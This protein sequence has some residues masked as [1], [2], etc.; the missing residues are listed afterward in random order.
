MT[1]VK[2]MPYTIY[3]ENTPNPASM[4]FVANK[5]LV[6]GDPKEYFDS[7]SAKE[8]P[9][10]IRLF[11]FPFVKSVFIS[12]NYITINKTDLT[13]WE[14]VTNELRVMI[15]EFLNEGNLVLTPTDADMPFANPDPVLAESPLITSELDQKITDI[16]NE[17]IRPAVEQD[18]GAIQY[19]SFENGV[20]TVILRGACSGCPSAT[21]TLKSGIEQLLKRLVPEVK[22]VIADE[23]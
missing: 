15:A 21:L 16:L 17:Y 7:A 6:E 3:I 8:S 14:E 12:S 20:V 5:L 11:Q 10:A 19:K 13:E 18:G 2:Q 1:K 9:L 23:I 4:K 22:E